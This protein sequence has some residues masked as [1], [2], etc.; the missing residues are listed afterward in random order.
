[1]LVEEA[2]NRVKAAGRGNGNDWAVDRVI[3]FLNTALQQVSAYLV[4]NRY[5]PLVKTVTL[6]DNDSLPENYM[7]S[8]G[9]YPI[10]I[11]NGAVEFLGDDETINFRY[12]ANVGRVTKTSD[13]M[14]FTNDAINEVVVKAAVLLALNENTYNIAQD[15]QLVTTLQDAVAIGLSGKGPG[16]SP[17]TNAR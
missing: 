1:M 17:T 12:Y 11:T 13:N 3:D 8:C 2:V 15:T 7:F 6:H 9:T 4:A 10:R 16:V 5:P 14:P